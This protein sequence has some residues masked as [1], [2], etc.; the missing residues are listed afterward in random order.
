MAQKGTKARMLFIHGLAGD[1]RL[2]WGKMPEILMSDPNISDHYDIDFYSYPTSLFR[3][4]FSKKAPRIQELA[5]GLR[6]QI[7]YDEH[8]RFVLVCHSLGGLIARKYIVDQLRRRERLKV[9]KL[10]LFAVP[11]N[12]SG[13]AATAKHISWRQSQLRQL[14]YGSDAIEMLNE[15]WIHLD[16]QDHVEVKFVVGTQDRIVDRFSVAGFWGNP[17]LETITGVGHI[18]I[19]KP[20]NPS[21]LSVRIVTEFIQERPTHNYALVLKNILSLSSSQLSLL[22][23]IV[24]KDSRINPLVISNYFGVANRISG[25]NGI[26]LGDLAA[27]AEGQEYRDAVRPTWY[28]I[29]DM[30]KQGIVTHED[31]TDRL[32]SLTEDAVKAINDRL[33]ELLQRMV[34]IGDVRKPQ[35]ISGMS[36][37]AAEGYRDG[38]G[39]LLNG[40]YLSTWSSSPKTRT[41]VDGKDVS[42]PS[43]TPL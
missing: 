17:D 22:G 36:W 29:K 26:Y 42:T 14:C 19:V 1:A 2:T 30:E 37:S 41:F 12:G 9:E 6:T 39:K 33:N 32:I 18:D 27:V 40:I 21:D 10:I 4:P 34:S 43:A 16:A 3:L 13:L 38:D 7:E 28:M 8:E 11:N 20:K 5:N 24:L 15:D 25:G 23:K 35:M 31:L